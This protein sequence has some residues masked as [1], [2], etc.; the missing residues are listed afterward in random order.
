MA[1]PVSS[2]IALLLMMVASSCAFQF[3]T[4]PPGELKR[5]SRTIP[6]A[7]NIGKS[8]PDTAPAFADKAVG[9]EPEQ[10]H[11][12]YWGSP[13]TM[14]VTFASGNG[15][16]VMGPPG[17]PPE[18]TAPALAQWGTKAGRLLRNA[19]CSTVSYVQNQWPVLKSP[20]YVSP[21]LTTCLLKGLPTNSM[22]FYRVGWPTYEA[23]SPTYKFKTYSATANF[24][25][26]V[27]V[28]ADL[29]LSTHTLS[30]VRGMAA[31]QPQVVLN[32]GDLPYADNYLPTG[33]EGTV[34]GY[35]YL[36]SYQ[37]RWDM[38]GRLM[39]GLAAHV[40]VM[41]STGNH[42]IEFQ[43]D[44]TV[45]AAYNTRYPVPQDPSKPPAPKPNQYSDENPSPTNNMYYSWDV[46]G[47]AHFI[48]L[49]SY[50]PN[51][52]FTEDTAQYKWLAADLAK[53]DRK[54]T[55]WLI[56]YF[57]APFVTSYEASFKQVECMR[58]TYEPLLYKYG[59]D[60]ILNGHVHAYER[61]YN[62]YNFTLD[63]CGPVHITIGCGG[64]PGEPGSGVA[65]L[66]TKYIEEGSFYCKD[67]T[68][69]DIKPNVAQPL[70]CH[71]FQPALGGFCWDRQPDFSAFRQPMFGAAMLTLN[72]ATH[73]AWRFY[74]AAASGAAVVADS[75]NINRLQQKGCANH[76]HLG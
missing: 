71:T 33:D 45:F 52:T 18:A 27:G 21:Y 31:T 48:A 44:G 7:D 53:V 49:T 72:N 22:V 10:V 39:Q 68:V 41:T 67:P 75:V 19:S 14:A 47:T 63:K 11:L 74:K 59:A 62:T 51:D 37:P 23:W 8:L 24:P 46:P 9:F 76:P 38:F 13:S 64:K 50:I 66:D 73:A 34:K 6:E 35:K 61:F 25:F 56:A 20:S 29:G 30:V 2:S 26:K 43:N 60:L 16:I 55:P 1:R 12:T 32:I 70:R 3:S 40:P 65:A 15:Q 57:H 5:V 36:L 54:K 4:I 42:E 28:M 69:L 58:L 17:A